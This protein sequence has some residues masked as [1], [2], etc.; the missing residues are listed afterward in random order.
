MQEFLANA[1]ERLA[2]VGVLVLVYGAIAVMAVLAEYLRTRTAGTRLQFIAL[3]AEEAVA[4]QQ[5]WAEDMREANGG[6]LTSSDAEKLFDNALGD[7]KKWAK[8]NRVK[9]AGAVV[10]EIIGAS[11]E[12]A[13]WFQK[14]GNKKLG[15]GK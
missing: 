12:S 1:M 9:V 4:A 8:E 2:E 3:A 14:N 6:V 15:G 10:A 11:I 5:Q 7:V 13:V